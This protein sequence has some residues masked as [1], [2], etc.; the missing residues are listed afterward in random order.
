MKTSEQRGFTLIEILVAL[1]IFL[2]ITAIVAV[3]YRSANRRARDG[4]RQADIEEVRTKLEIYRA[5]NPGTGYPTGDWSA[6]VASL[7]PT[8]LTSA[9]QDPRPTLYTYY[10]AGTAT[11]YSLC[12]YLEA[13]DPSPC[14]VVGICGLVGGEACNFCQ[15][16][17]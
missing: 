15:C 5:D 17:P 11:N 4:N 9:A 14:P 3:S 10:Y 7:V 12:A 1:G 6:M 13:G 2:M 8:Y 16:N